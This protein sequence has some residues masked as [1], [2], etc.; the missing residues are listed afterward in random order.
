MNL[1]RLQCQRLFA[2]LLLAGLAQRMTS[3]ARADDTRWFRL[4][5]LPLASL[6]MEVEGS[7][8]TTRVSGNESTY[9]HLFLTPLLGLQT[10][11][12]IYHPN[13]LA[14]DVNGELGWGWDSTTARSSGFNR[15]RNESAELN[16]YFAQI[17]LL[18][19]KPYNASFFASQDHTFR[20]YGTFDTFTVDSERYG[21]RINWNRANLS[22]NTDFGYRDEKSSGLND[23]SEIAETYFNFVGLNQRHYGQTTL[24]FRFNQFDN[25]FNYGNQTT[26]MN[27]SV[28]LSD[29]ETF[30]RRHQI[31]ASTG[32]SFGHSSYSGRESDTFNA[33]E[34]FNI[35]HRPRLDSFL[36]LDFAHNHLHPETQSRMQGTYG[37]RH[38]LFESL[39]SNLDAHGSH[40]ENHGAL[41]S[42]TTDRYGLGLYENYTKRLRSWGRLTAG[43]GIVADHEEDNANGTIFTSI[44][45]SHLLYLPTSPNYRPVYLNRPRVIAGTIVVNVGGD[46]LLESTDY[47]VVTS[48]ELTEI[49]LLVPPSSHLQSLLLASDNLTV[50]ATYQSA[51]LNNA[52]FESLNGSAQVR[53]DLPGG[54][55]LYSRANWMENN[56]PAEILVQTL[57]DFVGGVDYSWHWLRAG[58]EY[59]NYDSNFTQ[60]QAFRCYQNFDFRLDPKSTLNFNFNETFYSY[61]GGRDQTQ[62]QFLAR[63]TSR[64]WT[65]F[66]WYLEGGLMIQEVLGTDQLQGSARTGFSWRRGKLSVRAG[67]EYNAQTTSSGLWTEERE[68]QRLFG[69]MKRTF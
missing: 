48:G 10:S 53:L 13:L 55:G 44:D 38:Q 49:R 57:T 29:S 20:D 21:G 68:K 27:Q 7:T 51:S 45:E 11:G 54:V 64:L 63:Y 14:F 34:H 69:Y 17:T 65:D 28:G 52:S 15:T 30:G 23:A 9:D 47:Q 32:L 67:Y 40:Q 58:A 33:N 22:L 41:S 3:A 2:S 50:L 61:P 36:M 59:E 31:T 12:S 56:A 5:G 1:S 4:N 26:S 37:L 62:Y 42:S 18:Q 8:E 39:T 24:T 19:A 6:G 60:Y 16:R 46:V 43:A 25:L 35:N 66:S